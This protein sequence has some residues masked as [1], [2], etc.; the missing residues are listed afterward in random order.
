MSWRSIGFVYLLLITVS[1]SAWS[2]SF[3]FHD[4]KGFNLIE[5]SL[6]GAYESGFLLGQISATSGFLEFDPAAPEKTTGKIIAFTNTAQA[7]ARDSNSFLKGPVLFDVERYPTIT[8]DVQKMAQGNKIGQS[9]QLVVVGD[10]TIKG[11]KRKVTIPVH[12]DYFPGKLMERRKIEGDLLVVRSEFRIKRSDYDLGKGK[13]LKKVADEVKVT[14]TLVGAAPKIR[15]KSPL[16][17]LPLRTKSSHDK[18]QP[19]RHPIRQSPTPPR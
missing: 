15:S 19:Q 16:G 4:P 3:D 10:L 9:V 18:K 8:F 6:A 12:M 2:K 14:M 7:Q 11:I 17:L 5:F 1:E 13:L